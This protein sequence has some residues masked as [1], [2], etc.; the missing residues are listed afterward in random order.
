MTVDAATGDT[1]WSPQ[2]SDLGTHSV[3][4]SV[5]D[6][7]GGTATQQFTVTARLGPPNR[8]PVI[9][10]TP[11]VDG[12]VN[13]A[14]S[15]QVMASDPDGTKPTDPTGETLTYSVV[16]GPAGLSIDP[17]SGLVS[18]T[19]AAA[20]LGTNHVK[21]QV[22]D[23]RGGT[24]TQTYDIGVQQEKGNLPPHI[25]S[26]PVTQ[27]ILPLPLTGQGGSIFVT[28]EDP[29]FHG[30]QGPN[31]AGA[32]D[33][34]RDGLAFVRNGNPKP[35]LWVES[36]ITPPGG[37]SP[38]IN[39]IKAA[40]FTEGKDFVH[41][42]AAGI[43][44]VNFQDY[45]A[46][47]VAS[48]AGGLLTQAELDALNARANDIAQFVS[49][50]G[51][52]L[53]FAESG[54]GV[55][56]TTSHQFGFLPFLASSQVKDQSE[57]GN[58]VTAAGRQLGLLTSDVN[59]NFSHNIFLSDGGMQVVARDSS[60]AILGLAFRGKL[61]S[62]GVAPATPYTY[63]AKA[64]D[65]DSDPLTYSLP[66]GPQ[67]MTIDPKTGLIT[68]AGP[69]V[70]G[71]GGPAPISGL[72][73]TAAALDAGFSLTDFVHAVPG[74]Q[75]IGPLGIAFPASGGVLSSSN[76]GD[77]RL[78][79][80]DTDGQNAAGIPA[81][82]H[83]GVGKAF[84]MAQA[85]STIY[86]TQR[87]TG[88]I[89][90]LN[91]DGTFN[92]TI[93][94][95]LTSP[96]GIVI[97]PT[98]G[99]L[100]VS[101]FSSNNVYDV[102]PVAKTASVLFHA[103]LDGI[104][105][106]PDGSALYG[107]AAPQGTDHVYGYSLSPGS[108]GNQVFDSGLVAGD[109]DGSALG[110]G[111]LAGN[112]FANTNQGTVVEINLQTKAQTT[113]ASGGS[114]GD[115]VTVDPNDG[116]LL[117]TQSDEIVRLRPPIGA[118]FSQDFKV[119]VRVDDGRGAF[120]TQSYTL[121]V[122]AQPGEIEGTKFNDLNG[123][124]IRDLQGGNATPP[125]LLNVPAA[126][127]PYLAGQVDGAG[128]DNGDTAP[129]ESPILA[130]G[131]ALTPGQPLM[132]TVLAGT[133]N[134]QSGPDGGV[135]ATHAALNG[136]SGLHAPFWSLVGVFLGPN[137]PDPSSAPAPLDFYD[138]TAVPGG[139]DYQSVSPQ[140]GQ[141]FFIGDGRT[142]KGD[143]Q[144]VVVPTGAT[145][146]FLATA[147]PTGWHANTG[148]FAVEV[149]PFD[150]TN[151]PAP[152]TLTPIATNFNSLIHTDYYEPDNTLIASVNYGGGQ[153][154][155]F[156]EIMADGSHVPF[157]NVSGFSDEVYIAIA[158]SSDLGGFKP[159]DLFVGNGQDGQIA[160]ITDNGQTLI[161]PWV[162]LP[163][164]GHGLFRGYVRFDRTGVFGGDLIAETNQGEVWRIDATGQ[165]TEVGNTHSF[166]EGVEVIPND[167]TRYGPL[168]G[169]ILATDESSSGFY[170]V[171]PAGQVTFFDIGVGHLEDSHV[172]PANENFF[173]ADF[174][175]GRVLA[176]RASQ[177]TSMVGDILF[178]QE[179]S[180]GLFRMFWDGKALQV[181]P[182]DYA[183][184][185]TSANSWEGSN[186]APAGVAPLPPVPVE[187]G[188]P[189][190][191]IYL[192]LNHDGKLD[193]GDPSTTTDANGHYAFT[194]VPPST[195]TV[196]E[197]GQPGW[198]QTAPAG[199][200]H[201][202]T[203][204]PGQVTSGVDFGNTQ[205]NVS[206]TPRPPAFTNAAPTSATV[207]QLYRYDPTI[208]NPDG[209]ALTFD[210]PAHPV[211]MAIDPATGVVAWLPSSGEV[212]TQ[213]V[214]LR[215]EDSR[216]QLALQSFQITVNPA[217]SAPV[218][219]STPPLQ[220][221][222]A[223]PYQ[224]RVHAQ[225]AAGNP[226]TFTL[227]TGPAGMAIDATGLLTYTPTAAQAGTQHVHLTVDNGHGGQAIQQFDL[228]VVASAP[229]ESPVITSTPRT[230]VRLG[231]TYLYMVQANDPDGDPLTYSLDA[232]APNGMTIDATG[233]VQW[234]P[235]ADQ[236]GAN[237][238][239]VRV[240]DV[241][242]ASA[243]PQTFT[244]NVI[245]QDVNHPPVITSAPRTA[246]VIG[247]QYQYD[248][249]AEDSDGDPV[250]WSL[251]QGPVGMSIDPASGKVRWL[252][253]SD[254]L[255]TQDVIIQAQDPLLAQATQSFTITVHTVDVPPVITSSPPTEAVAA[256]LYTYAV[257]ASD[258]QNNTLNWSL[259]SAPSGMTIDAPTGLI[260]WTPG[261]TQVGTQNVVI[262]AD[263]GQGGLATQAYQVVVSDTAGNKAPVITSPP[264]LA[265]TVGGLYSYAVKAAD[266]D[267]DKVT[268]SLISAPPGMTIDPTS[269]QVNWTPSAAELGTNL[270]TIA[271]TD[272]AG[273]LGLQR[274]AV[275]AQVNQLPTISSKAITTVTAGTTYRY[276]IRASDSDG[277]T[278]TYTITTGPNG[279]TVDAMGRV[280]WSPAI[281][282]IG[283][284]PI[285]LTVA[286]S[287]GATATQR[288]DLIVVADTQPPT[289]NLT[290]SATR[291]NVGTAVTI[292]ASATDDVAVQ[293]LTVTVGGTPVILDSHG[294]STVTMP[295]VG[296][297]TVMATATDPAGNVGTTTATL[298]VI[299]P[300]ATGGPTVKITSPTDNATIMSLTQIVGTVSDSHLDF[301]RVDYAPFDKVDLNNLA[302]DN[303][304]FV[305][306]TRSSTPVTNGVLATFDPTMLMND[307]YVVRVFAQNISG[308]ITAAG[309]ILSVS[310]ELKLGDFTQSFTDLSIPLAGI[311]I[312]V[313]RVYDTK[314]ASISGDFGFGWRLGIQDAHIHKTV[315]PSQDGGLL[316]SPFKI[317][318]KVYLTN[319]DGKREGFT[320]NPYPQS[321]LFFGTV[322][323]PHFDPD[324]GVFDQ[325]SVDDASLENIGGA[326]YSF[327][328]PF[329]FNP[330]EFTLTARD[331][332]QY[333]YNDTT[334]LEKITDL[335]G[336]NITFTNAGI[337]S[338]TG[339]AVAFKRN[340]AGRLAE[341]DDPAGNTITYHY[342]ANG[343]LVATTDQ[344]GRTSTY[345]YRMIPAHYLDTVTD[346]QGNTALRTAYDDQ[347]RVRATTDAQGNATARSYDSSTFTETVTDPL[348]NATR[349]IYDNRGNIVSVKNPM[350]VTM[351]YTYDTND[352]VITTTNGLGLT[353]RFTYDDRGNPAGTTDANNNTTR[354]T[355]T[356][357]NNVSTATDAAGHTATYLYDDHGKLVQLVNAMGSSSFLTYDATGRISGS[358]DNSGHQTT[359]IYG[360]SSHP[361]VITE[362]G[363]ATRHQEYNDLG[364]PTRTVDENGNERDYIYDGS[365]DPLSQS[366]SQGNVTTFGYQGQRLVSITDPLGNVRRFMYDSAGNQTEAINTLGGVEQ[367][368]YDGNGR[369]VK[370][371]PPS[372]AVTINSWR[373][374]GQL[375]SVTELSGTG[376]GT[377]DHVTSYEYDGA[378]NRTG[379]TDANGHTTNFEYDALGHITRVTDALAGV[380]S[381]TYDALGNQAS[382]T[383]ADG[384]TTE[385]TYDPLGD[386]LT[387]TDA[388]GHTSSRT[389]DPNG[390]LASLTDAN[391]HT[392]LFAYDAR[393][394][395]MQK[396]DP[397]GN[398]IR[399]SYDGVG[400]R[401]SVTDQLGNVTNYTY[402][403]LNR[404]AKTTDPLGGTTVNAY[405]GDDLR[406][407]VTDA[408]GRR[409]SFTY[410][411]LNRLVSQTDPA[412][413]VTRYAYDGASNV[414]ALTDPAG[415]TTSYAYDVFGN[416]VQETDPLGHAT[417]YAYD[418]V[419][420]RTRVT[421]RD[422]RVRTFSYDAANQLVGENWLDHGTVIRRIGYTYDP[423]GNQ[424][425][426]TDPDS[427]YSFTYDAANQLTGVDNAGTP[428][429]PHVALHYSYDAAGNI[430]SVQDNLGVRVDST[431]DARDLLT[432][433]TWQ[434]GG[435]AP[436]RVDFSY[437]PR[438][439]RTGVTRYADLTTAQRVDQSTLAYDSVGHLTTLTYRNVA[440]AVLASYAYT[441]D[442]AGQLIAETHDKQA[443][444][445][446]YDLAGQ[447]T[448]ARQPGGTE[449]DYTYDA[450]GN[451][452]GTG[453]VIGPGN[454]LLSD[455]TFRYAYD[456]EGNLIAK[457]SIGT[458][459]TTAY[460]YDFRNRL[461]SI[462]ETDASGKLLHQ[463]KFTYDVFDRRIAQEVDNTITYTV[464]ERNDVAV[465]E[466]GEWPP[467]Q[468]DHVWSDFNESGA[469]VARYLTGAGADEMLARFRPDEGTIW[470]LTD[471]LGTVRDL[472][473]AS[474]AVVN[475][476][477]YDSFGKVLAES[478]LSV[479]DRFLFTG[480][481]YDPVTGLYYYRA[482][483]Y[484]PQTGR[485]LSEDPMRFIAGDTNLYRYVKN[486]PENTIDPTGQTATQEAQATI[487]IPAVITARV[488]LTSGSYT[489]RQ[490]VFTYT[491]GLL[492]FITQRFTSTIGT[493]LLPTLAG[494]GSK[495]GNLLAL[496]VKVGV[497][498]ALVKGSL[499]LKVGEKVKIGKFLDGETEAGTTVDAQGGTDSSQPWNQPPVTKPSSKDLGDA[500]DQE[501][502]RGNFN[503]WIKSRQ[504]VF[505]NPEAHHLV[506]S[507]SPKAAPARAAL[508]NA[509]IGINDVDNGVWL[510]KSDKNPSVPNSGEIT[511][512]HTFENCYY[513]LIG[514]LIGN[515]GP[516]GRDEIIKA[517]KNLRCNLV[518][519]NK[520]W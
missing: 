480:R 5:D 49:G 452:S 332:R 375:E 184:G 174:G 329:P 459:D 158:R 8:P 7:R 187:P 273:A 365:G 131:V 416:L 97:N 247:V 302:A 203:V 209:F 110:V 67:G 150:P 141:V 518:L 71:G 301:Y 408:F 270:V 276:D 244:V 461:T 464:Y 191:T 403:S 333:R 383:D 418:S 514:N 178:T 124:G 145:R 284:H 520:Q 463:E 16:S 268:F 339:P 207:S 59:G 156:E 199:G 473:G 496:F 75:G 10:S 414:I 345:S 458:G 485:F 338:S 73:L 31:A 111:T 62:G 481:E 11:V 510:P 465:T 454:Q 287:L 359:Y 492:Y 296:K 446:T 28:G 457:T 235:T 509:C 161:N 330:D 251:F 335:N 101:S 210:L 505:T 182:L 436:V 484:D 82:Q 483:Y 325:L 460:T 259:L 394:Q 241:R 317:G 428:A 283:S 361:T 440:D 475:H 364:E 353:T 313:T 360:T 74:A 513:V 138:T 388:L 370:D 194:N 490:F 327:F 76:T 56:L 468:G 263:D 197:V 495:L 42:D 314:Q 398:T 269:G 420:N 64:I 288:F 48:D 193:P 214:V 326:F 40:G 280:S 154:R 503:E 220:A 504:D 449:A 387:M 15:Y 118:S 231:R 208:S 77:V 305:T 36:S 438:G 511:H 429:V 12:N 410:D 348:G 413:G 232:P 260:Q 396:T 215:V 130:S 24:A 497:V 476:I 179:F 116:S 347:G 81:T 415:Q 311:P 2:A 319:A 152:I 455:G 80:T 266:P 439:E 69:S 478:G 255:G 170:S 304:A 306:I 198:R 443:T 20:Q 148:S 4:L 432:S 33:I 146:L 392:S 135:P 243:P 94:T 190:W 105:I 430:T 400:N 17:A 447:L 66:I 128:A 299:D 222:V 367:F 250:V 374:D 508:F 486:S 120:D 104:T 37:Y 99:H 386:L 107:A 51:G 87:D 516:G 149:A 19:P 433:R 362:P 391:G 281:G 153:P 303:P 275:V 108:V 39:A 434:G 171:T 140:L 293:Q 384:N 423:A 205:L 113:I 98:N 44:T 350:G 328:I 357:L 123:N 519:G 53:A 474:G 297:F 63:A 38:G 35:F 185:S 437:D 72:A 431:Y 261:E 262:Q 172:I 106:S 271:A 501:A 234:T 512:N 279:M 23:G 412:G 421:D 52:L 450:N 18:W 126:A 491:R 385:F 389:Y 448:A 499:D 407:A 188:L 312:T 112:I 264:P 371:I 248:P 419:D 493:N 290:L 295:T 22:D 351:S 498:T 411:A 291:I 323:H 160:R 6:G 96:H 79:P 219:T 180:G 132:F 445:Y 405:N 119:T 93:V 444:T 502:G 341:I 102:D 245:S 402:D 372:G 163:G 115:F 177:L 462:Q 363:G 489:L 376:S 451:R 228:N 467:N 175:S 127:D 254:Q 55:P 379:V 221:V 318:T 289:I 397:A 25:V 224:Y 488:L 322:W 378:G 21:L 358:T 47:A 240:T 320:F 229:N 382:A 13:T 85:G 377:S 100:I 196:A 144:Q 246:G 315:P 435:V 9:T 45:S 89:I 500:L 300:A 285:V 201:T 294:S 165:A 136:I 233:L 477:D 404:L 469:V 143:V 1:T 216:G 427:A 456:A 68:W 253:T 27:Y 344:V 349:L 155:N 292:N 211:G 422:G 157:S 169:T 86:M 26:Q 230:A 217:S 453:Y 352:N 90:Q 92:Q 373:A 334:G 506:P 258:V 162:T 195:Y 236:F 29:D 173:G 151:G 249:N 324:P 65:A 147:G 206:S 43:P 337:T 479:A 425:S 125:P 50:G 159:G 380:Q 381:F 121:H 109:P 267:G 139:L 133:A 142:S 487:T 321:L 354:V 257:Q 164:T 213:T 494:I 41:V 88:A 406:T 30:T 61:T 239:T 54:L 78:F 134:G 282:D 316:A 122:G 60:G 238:V 356:S 117:L 368:I 441:Y 265:A 308:N 424:L 515:A 401:T 91:D 517:L 310:G 103:S 252:P 272:P 366:D 298:F 242:G 32:L 342:N 129:A 466:S 277:D 395:L 470:Y 426:A 472:A 189:N 3:I 84:D 346:P 46:I 286:D 237:M 417:S 137:A 166:L 212:G 393:G 355:Y 343:D 482:R 58:V 57:T 256:A 167:P 331:G 340:P 369:V 309:I 225:D 399:M 278:L 183:A 176:I 168:A 181:Q 202:V 307:S 186:F 507:G 95:G 200:T 274:Y 226:F 227:D 83:Y 70:G 192:D 204:L 390:N 442:S 218:I 114:R 409:T 471:H 34:I 223:V 336:N 14:Y